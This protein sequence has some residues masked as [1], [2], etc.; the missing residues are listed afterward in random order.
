[1]LENKTRPR[2]L[3]LDLKAHHAALLAAE[4]HPDQVDRLA[5]AR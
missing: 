2:R 1:M 4:L 5:A 3:H